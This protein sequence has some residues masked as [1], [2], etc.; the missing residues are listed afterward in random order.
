[1]GV[2]EV[3]K[4][5]KLM[6]SI[7][8]FIFDETEKEENLNPKETRQIKCTPFPLPFLFSPI[9]NLNFHL[10]QPVLPD[11]HVRRRA[12]LPVIHQNHHA[13]R[14]HA[15][16]NVEVVVL[17]VCDDFLGVGGGTFFE[18]RDVFFGGAAGFHGFF[19]FFH[20][21]CVGWLVGWWRW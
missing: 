6:I 13:I 3:A 16:A 10:A 20:V 11:R 21:R 9:Q 8:L 14:V 19:D 2:L 17:E 5:N 7:S 4:G 12:V 1:M 18:S 15:L